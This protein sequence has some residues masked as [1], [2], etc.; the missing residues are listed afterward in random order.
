MRVG[1]WLTWPA[2]AAEVFADPEP[3]WKNVCGHIGR[4]IIAPNIPPERMPKDPGMN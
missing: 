4:R 3:L 1:G 2:E